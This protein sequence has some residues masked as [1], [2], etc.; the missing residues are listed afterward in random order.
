M[1]SLCK[2]DLSIYKGA[3]Q[4]CYPYAKRACLYTRGQRRDVISMQRGL[5]YIQGGNAEML[6]LRK[7]GLSIH[8]GVM[9]REFI[10]MQ[11][12]FIYIQVN[13]V[14]RVYPYAKKVYLCTRG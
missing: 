11:R 8:K 2:E 7:E 6:S 3:T 12:R 9:Q 13:H 1:L 10:P 14:E 5:V 4:R